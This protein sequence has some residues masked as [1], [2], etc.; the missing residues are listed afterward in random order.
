MDNSND[1]HLHD[2]D[3]SLFLSSNNEANNDK[4][5]NLFMNNSENTNQFGDFQKFLDLQDFQN[6]NFSGNNEI[7]SN[8]K[9]DNNVQE[10]RKPNQKEQQNSIQNQKKSEL[11]SNKVLNSDIQ[12]MYNTNDVPVAIQSTSF[13]NELLPD[14]DNHN[15]NIIQDR[16]FDDMLEILPDGLDLFS[17]HDSN[18]EKV[19]DNTNPMNIQGNVQNGEIA[20]FWTFNVEELLSSAPSSLGSTTISAPNSTHSQ[21]LHSQQSQANNGNIPTSVGGF[22]KPTLAEL[23]KTKTNTSSVS[24]TTIRRR[25]STASNGVKTQK[26]SFLAQNIKSNGVDAK[27]SKPPQQCY[28][29]KT[30][31]TPLW[32]RDSNGNTL[33]NA[34]GLFH[35]LHGTMRPLSLKSDVIKKRNAKKK[36]HKNDMNDGSKISKSRNPSVISINSNSE[37]TSIGSG[38]K[39][40]KG[41]SING[42]T[43]IA[44]NN[45]VSNSININNKPLL[46]RRESSSSSLT[47]LKAKNGLKNSISNSYNNSFISNSLPGNNNGFG[48]PSRSRESSFSSSVGSTNVSNKMS[49]PI[50]PKKKYQQNSNITPSNSLPNGTNI[51]MSTSH[52]N[53]N[54]SSMSGTN[55]ATFMST[56][57]F[58]DNSPRFTQGSVASLSPFTNMPG[59]IDTSYSVVST[60]SEMNTPLV[61]GSGL[62]RL[63]QTI[64]A[65][66]ISGN[67]MSA[68]NGTLYNNNF[69]SQMP[70]TTI[71]NNN[72]ISM[73]GNTVSQYTMPTQ[74]S[75]NN[76]GKVSLLSQGLKNKSLTHGTKINPH[77]VS[78]MYNSFY[79]DSAQN[80]STSTLNPNAI[81]AGS[82]ENT[83]EMDMQDNGNTDKDDL[84]WLK[85]GM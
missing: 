10:P 71:S 14:F 41:K 85:F 26:H 53:Y 38:G 42:N 11:D 59:T 58:I 74:R 39:K 80:S 13:K 78:S 30:L 47:T 32:R 12:D 83:E 54:Q 35:K 44:S 5:L 70:S 45:S 49:I 77:E 16:G 79:G 33:C 82:N 24:N 56:G 15:E 29:C 6:V 17:K 23:K 43:Q 48:K 19:F 8:S 66:N 72:I 46:G 73:N 67:S 65:N 62:H 25:S 60:P 37:F 3:L 4:D 64:S 69:I 81:R 18:E 51:L 52:P 1:Y 57:S 84:S 50:L 2:Q 63:S 20:N 61:S 22:G 28:N 68:G 76:Q 36:D 31:K 7:D 21:M 40:E 55:G 9:N 75:S 34:C 27:D